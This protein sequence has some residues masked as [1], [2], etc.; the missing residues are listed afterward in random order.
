MSIRDR[1]AGPRERR[2]VLEAIRAGR[3]VTLDGR[4]WRYAAGGAAMG[5]MRK[6]KQLI[7][8]ATIEHLEAAGLCRPGD[9]GVW[10]LTA[11]GHDEIDR[12]IT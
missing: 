7:A 9:D 6:S 1:L 3:V 10:M 11:K 4:V 5:R 8:R 12:E 2:G